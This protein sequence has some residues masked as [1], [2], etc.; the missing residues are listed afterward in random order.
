MLVEILTLG[1]CSLIRGI[2]SGLNEQLAG[3]GGGN[4]DQIINQIFEASMNAY[5]NE[6]LSGFI[7]LFVY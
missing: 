6:L 5:V 7:I 2:F 1:L 4:L 3:A